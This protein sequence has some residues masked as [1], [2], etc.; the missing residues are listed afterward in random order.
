[1]WNHTAFQCF[2]SLTQD[3]SK[4]TE[5]E[6]ITMLWV[7]CSRGWCCILGVNVAIIIVIC[8]WE[9]IMSHVLVHK[10]VQGFFF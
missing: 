1:M 2:Q 7:D 3:F 10:D 6:Y 8:I 5:H 4:D 9:E